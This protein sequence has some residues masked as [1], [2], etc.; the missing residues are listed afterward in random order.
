M[1]AAAQAANRYNVLAYRQKVLWRAFGSPIVHLPASL[2]NTKRTPGSA[3]AKCL[4]RMNAGRD[5]YISMTK[6]GRN[7]WCSE[8][9]PQAGGP[10]RWVWL[11]PSGW[12]PEPAYASTLR[13]G[14]GPHPG[15]GKK[16]VSGHVRESIYTGA[17]SNNARCFETWWV[18]ESRSS[19]IRLHQLGSVNYCGRP[20]R[21]RLGANLK[22]SNNVTLGQCQ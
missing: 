11:V 9:F 10:K 8:V 19:S 21:A 18:S 17:S 15:Q 4:S 6:N 2:P 13:C 5:T 14:R 1:L 16:K 20:Q 3:N 7:A 12:V 22:H